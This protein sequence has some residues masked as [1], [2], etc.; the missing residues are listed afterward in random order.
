[1]QIEAIDRLKGTFLNIFVGAMHRVTSLEPDHAPPATL[2]KECAG[3]RWR[4]AILRKRLVL[5][6]QN[7]HRATEKH[8]TLLIDH[9]DTRMVLVLGTIDL[10]SFKLLIVGKLLFDRHHG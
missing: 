2:G 4:V 5:Q 7:A 10:A 3:L 9:L 8:I 1:M 6:V